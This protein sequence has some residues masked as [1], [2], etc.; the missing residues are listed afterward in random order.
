[1]RSVLP[2]K[3]RANGSTLITGALEEA[4]RTLLA[5]IGEGI[6]ARLSAAAEYVLGW[7]PEC[8]PQR[9]APPGWRRYA[10]FARVRRPGLARR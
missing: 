7:R 5:R 1:M 10:N 2:E 8:R 6:G 3:R 9:Y 4:Q